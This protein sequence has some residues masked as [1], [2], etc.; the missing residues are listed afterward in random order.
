MVVKPNVILRLKKSSISDMPVTISAL[1]M[2][3]L[4]I[5]MRRARFL[6]FI[7]CIAIHAIVPITVATNADMKAISNV[8]KSACIITLS[9][10]RLEYHFNVKPPHFALVLLALN[11]RTIRV[12]IGA[13]KKIKISAI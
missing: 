9:E 2:G 3:I 13:Y 1:S 8:F 11:D 6:F 7:P 12:T 10:K 5:P 4:D